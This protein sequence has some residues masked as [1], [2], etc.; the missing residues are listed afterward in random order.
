MSYIN[1]SNIILKQEN[2]PKN[3]KTKTTESDCVNNKDVCTT[4]EI[5]EIIDKYIVNKNNIKKYIRKR[6]KK[7]VINEAK[8]ILNCNS[9]ACVLMHPVIKNFINE[10]RISNSLQVD[11]KPPGPKYTTELLNNI[12]IDS[13]LV[14]WA[15]EFDGFYPCPFTMIDFYEN[16]YF[17]FGEI[18]L[19]NLVNKKEYY[20]DPVYGKINKKFNCFGCVL[21]TDKS[22]GKGKHWVC[23]YVNLGYNDDIWTIEYFNSTGNIPPAPVIKW[24]EQQRINLLTINNKVNTINVSYLVHQQSMTEC[25]LYSLYYIR[26]RLDK[27]SY[28]YF[29]QNYIDDH[30]MIKFREHV[31]RNNN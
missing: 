21:N 15:R 10:N 5:V 18:N 11:F 23:I 9:E 19:A 8:K 28:E 29:L 12:N 20:Y 31:F 25:G 2:H 30:L 3:L 14:N 4:S 7:E 6:N 17:K 1:K 22:S 26:S 27:I 24:M 13:T 16:N